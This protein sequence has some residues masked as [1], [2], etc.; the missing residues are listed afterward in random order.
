MA[1]GLVTGTLGL[2][3]ATT[4]IIEG[5]VHPQTERFNISIGQDLNT[6]ALHVDAR[7]HYGAATN[8]IVLNSRYMGV[9]GEEVRS[10]DFPFHQ[11][12]KMGVTIRYGM[13]HMRITLQDTVR[14]EFPNRLDLDVVNCLFVEGFDLHSH[15]VAKT[16]M[17]ES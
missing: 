16:L 11:G 7:F 15:N 1:Q 8:T 12:Q 17:E 2:K 4:L 10:H 14:I 5:I 3:P 6:L 9:W 13:D